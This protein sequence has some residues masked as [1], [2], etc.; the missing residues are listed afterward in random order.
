MTPKGTPQGGEADLRYPQPISDMRP[1]EAWEKSAP[2]PDCTILS[3]DHDVTIR[4]FPRDR[5]LVVCDGNEHVIEGH[6]AAHR[7]AGKLARQL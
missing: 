1:A 3:T 4:A 2:G 6:D 5:H 7:L